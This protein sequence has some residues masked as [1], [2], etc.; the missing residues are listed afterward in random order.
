M[1]MSNV[2]HNQNGHVALN[3]DHLDL[4]CVMVPFT[5][6]FALHDTHASEMAS[7]DHECYAAPHFY[8]LD[9]KNIMLPP[10]ML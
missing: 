1:L 2:M 10:M 4:R 3:S 9:L 7:Y 8:H 5:M 6:L